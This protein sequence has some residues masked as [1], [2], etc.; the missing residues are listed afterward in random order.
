M[1]LESLGSALN[2]Y[3]PYHAA[4]AALLA[5]NQRLDDSRKAYEQAIALSNAPSDIALLR[6]K[7][8][9]LGKAG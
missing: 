9:A 3:Q 2:S 6:T 5:H 1:A 4:W 7:M 8:A